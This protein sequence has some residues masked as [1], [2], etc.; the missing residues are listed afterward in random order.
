MFIGAGA[1]AYLIGAICGILGQ[2]D[3]ATANYNKGLDKLNY[4]SQVN[5][6]A[7][8]SLCHKYISVCIC[9]K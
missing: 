9:E 3:E 5:T 2:M 1:F 8:L 7:G 4:F 6:A